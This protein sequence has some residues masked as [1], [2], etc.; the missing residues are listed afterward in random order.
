VRT[1][2]IAPGTKLSHFEILEKT[3]EGG[4]GAVY[5]A[6]DLNL[7]RLVDIKLLSAGAVSNPERQARFVQENK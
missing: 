5:K 1:S 6:R 7:D 4:M 3:G 2:V